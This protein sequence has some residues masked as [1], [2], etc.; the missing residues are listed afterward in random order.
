[1]DRQQIDLIQSSFERAYRDKAKISTLFYENLFAA[2]PEAREMFHEDMHVQRQ[3]FAS[4]LVMIVKLL[5]QSEAM[6]GVARKLAHAH[7]RF[8]VSREQFDCAGEALIDALAEVGGD[9]FTPDT[10]QAW[11]QA[12]QVLFDCMAEEM[13]V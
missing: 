10:A 7:A 3:M 5:N 4:I 13:P 6:R 2:M 8:H 1:M 12:M 9:Q 11:R